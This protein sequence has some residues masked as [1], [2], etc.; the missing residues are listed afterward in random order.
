MVI[1][2][3]SKRTP[4]NSAT[5]KKGVKKASPETRQVTH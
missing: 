4:E 1:I 5:G 3:N 2:R